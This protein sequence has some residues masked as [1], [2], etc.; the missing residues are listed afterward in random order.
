[1]ICF[2]IIIFLNVCNISVETKVSAKVKDEL[3]AIR[4][5]NTLALH[6]DALRFYKKKAI[7]KKDFSA[8][9]GIDND[10][11]LLITNGHRNFSKDKARSIEKKLNLKHGILDIPPDFN[12]S[13][14]PLLIECANEFSQKMIELNKQTSREKAAAIIERVYLSSV[15]KGELDFAE[16]ETLIS[17]LP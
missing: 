5:Q 2:A 9:I 3:S 10:Y 13:I 17:L 1:M 15:D 14:P 8:Y 16:L 12:K 7:T 4:L 11:W 6:D